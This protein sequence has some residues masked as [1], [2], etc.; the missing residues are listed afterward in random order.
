MQLDTTDIFMFKDIDWENEIKW[1][2]LLDEKEIKKLKKIF[3]CFED[4][5]FDSIMFLKEVEQPS[6]RSNVKCL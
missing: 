1:F 4:V 2:Q 3:D 5:D 6:L